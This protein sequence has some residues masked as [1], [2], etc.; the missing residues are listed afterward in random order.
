[1]NVTRCDGDNQ[2]DFTD[3]YPYMIRV[4]IA[5]DHL[6]LLDGLKLVIESQDDLELAGS[7][8]SGEEVLHALEKIETDVLLLDINMNGMSGIETC[9]IVKKQYPG[10]KVIGL[11]TYDKGSVIRKMLKSGAV[12]YVLKN[13]GS[14]ELLKAV[15]AAARGEIYINQQ[16]NQLLLDELTNSTKVRQDFIPTLTR[17]EKEVLRLIA[18]EHTTPE[19]A[20]KL[21]ISQNTVESHRKNLLHKFGVKNVAGLV[22][23]AMEKGLLD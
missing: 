22:R 8:H 1:M 5:D 9:S 13:A 11:S 3:F 21:F 17:R 14:D 6:V 16:V 7:A 20:D 2:D 19:I 23:N 10:V 12:G 15:R 18:H 4:F